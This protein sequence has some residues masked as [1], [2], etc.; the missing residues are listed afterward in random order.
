MHDDWRDVEDIDT[1]ND[2]DVRDPDDYRD[3]L[4]DQA[5]FN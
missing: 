3:L 2:D 5:M 4:L 1:L